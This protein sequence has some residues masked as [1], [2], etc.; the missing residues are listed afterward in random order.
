MGLAFRHCRR[1]ARP[2]WPALRC[3]TSLLGGM[4]VISAMRDLAAGLLG[5]RR[6]LRRAV[7]SKPSQHKLE[8]NR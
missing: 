3:D 4:D 1:H 8:V 6:N 7:A 5:S 2:P